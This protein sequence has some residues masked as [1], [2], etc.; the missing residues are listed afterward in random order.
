MRT[1]DVFEM[2]VLTCH[3]WVPTTNKIFPYIPRNNYIRYF[4]RGSKFLKIFIIFIIA[5][6]RFIGVSSSR[7]IQMHVGKDQ[8]FHVLRLAKLLLTRQ[9]ST[10]EDNADLRGA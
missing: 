4:P 2:N 8:T 7:R 1:S 10:K 5:G 6:S 3:R 9:N